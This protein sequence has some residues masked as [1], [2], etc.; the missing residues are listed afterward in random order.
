VE[1]LSITTRRLSEP[2]TREVSFAIIAITSTT[3]GLKRRR[4]KYADDRKSRAAIV[5]CMMSASWQVLLPE[6]LG[7]FEK[8]LCERL[9]L[10]AFNEKEGFRSL[11]VYIF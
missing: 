1:A 2:I 3:D 10:G 4:R 11:D 7:S 9:D 8:P 5:A 6:G